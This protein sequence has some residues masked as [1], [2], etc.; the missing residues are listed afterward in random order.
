M[1]AH[2]KTVAWV[3]CGLFALAALI[4]VYQSVRADC[5]YACLSSDHVV[6][7]GA[8]DNAK[9]QSNNKSAKNKPVT[10]SQYGP[11]KK[12]KT[13]YR[14]QEPYKKQAAQKPSVTG[15]QY[16]PVKKERTRSRG[17]EPYQK[18]AA[19]KPAAVAV[20][21]P[22]GQRCPASTTI[23]MPA[24]VGTACDV[25]GACHCKNDYVRFLDG[26]W[27]LSS[28]NKKLDKARDNDL[29]VGQGS[30]GDLKCPDCGH[31]VIDHDDDCA[32]WKAKKKILPS[33][34]R[35]DD[36]PYMTQ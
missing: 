9:K 29:M 30:A 8:K 19:Q 34:E 31:L 6:I 21:C 35:F 28:G 27:V 11:V 18:Q 32:K 15:S 14:G 13:K 36:N 20:T 24:C 26:N 12:E 5:K 1:L 10:D 23:S 22:V 7:Q 33:G 2:K 16:G 4:G 17:Q 25:S 3:A